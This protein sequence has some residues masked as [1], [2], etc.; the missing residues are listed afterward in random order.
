M[1]SEEI[2]PEFLQSRG[3]VKGTGKI[4]GATG[5][6]TCTLS[7]WNYTVLSTLFHMGNSTDAN[8]QK[9]GSG[10]V[11]TI[12][13]LTNVII[14]GTTRNDAKAFRVTQAFARVT[15]PIATTLSKGEIA[16]L[17]VTFEALY[18]P[19]SPSTYPMFVEINIA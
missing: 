1:A 5:K 10:A 8:S 15:S 17:E 12:T 16:G 13:E 18:N 6:I 11:G 19:A 3:P 9:I 4:I 7:E 2:Y 14:T